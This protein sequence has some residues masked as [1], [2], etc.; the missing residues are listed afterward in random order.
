MS[1]SCCVSSNDLKLDFA[2]LLHYTTF[3]NETSG[4]DAVAREIFAALY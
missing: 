1:Y 4:G 3:K 2:L